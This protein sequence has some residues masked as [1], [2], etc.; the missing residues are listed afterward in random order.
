MKTNLLHLFKKHSYLVFGLIILVFTIAITYLLSYR[1]KPTFNSTSIFQDPEQIDTTIKPV[2]LGKYSYQNKNSLHQTSFRK[3][4]TNSSAIHF[5]NQYSDLSFFTNST[6]SFAEANPD[7]KPTVDGSTITYPAIFPHTDLRYTVEPNR[8]LEEFVINN[9]ETALTMTEITQTLDRRQIDSYKEVDGTIELY[10]NEQ[11]VATIPRPVMYEHSDQSIRSYDLNYTIKK[12]NNNTLSITKVVNDRGRDWLS[13]PARV[14][15]IVID[16]VIDNADTAASWVSSDTANT[17]VSQETTIKQE[18]TGSVKVATTAEADT[19]V[20]LM[21]YAPVTATGGTIT[22]SGGYTIHKFTSSGTFTP[23]GITDVE[24]LVVGG[25]GGGGETIGGGG[26]GGGILHSPTQVTATGHTVTVGAG[27]A[28]GWNGVGGTY[29]AGTKGS[30]SSFAGLVAKGGGAGGGYNVG[31]SVIGGSAGGNGAGGGSA[32]DSYT[33]GQGNSGGFN[34]GNTNT[35]GGGGGK[36]AAGSNATSTV[37]GSG[38]SGYTSTITGSSVTYAGGG[39]GGVRNGSGTAGSGGSGGGGAGGSSTA[40]TAGTANTG[41]GGGGGGYVSDLAGGAG[42]KGIVIIRYLTNGRTATPSY[43]NVNTNNTVSATGGTITNVG[44]FRIHKFTSGGTFTPNGAMNVEALVV[45]GGGGGGETIGGGGGGGGV[46][47]DTSFAVTATGYTITVGAGGAGGSGAGY[48]AGV[49]G[50]NSVFSTNTAIGG[51]AGAGYNVN[52]SGTGGS[53]GGGGGNGS[54]NAGYTPAQG[55]DGGN[56]GGA[57]ASGGGGGASA[58]GASYSGNNSGNGGDGLAFSITGEKLYYAGGGGGGVRNSTG[59][60]AGSAGTGGGGNGGKTTAGGGG[61]ANTGGGGGGGGYVSDLAGGAGGSGIVIIR[62]PFENEMPIGGIVTDVGDYRLH[63]YMST[64]TDIFVP[65]FST[66]VEVLMVGGGGGG[67]ETIGG[68]GGGG[69][70]IHNTS[71]AVTAGQHYQVTVGDGG[72]R[73]WDGTSGTY[74]AGSKGESSIFS[75]LTSIGG[76]GGAGYN[77]AAS[78]TGGSAG[79]NGAGGGA[80]AGYTAGQGNDGGTHYGNTN[81]SGGGGGKNAAGSNATSTVSGSGGSGYTSTI[82]GSSVTYAGGGGGGVRNGSGTAG[83]GGSGG[84]GTGGSSTAG[85]S[86]LTNTGGGGGGGGYV[87]DLAGGYGGSGIVIVKYLRPIQSY[88]ESSTKTQGSYALRGV[89]TTASLNKTLTR[90]VSPTLDLSDLGKINFS[91]RSTRTGSNIKIGI[92]D[93]GGTTTEITPNI[94]S[95]DSYQSIEWDISGVSNANKDAIDQIIITIVEATAANTFYIDNMVANDLSLN[96]TVTLTKS[97]TNLSGQD[98]ITYWVRSNTTGSFARFEF[99]ESASSEQTNAFTINSANT[100]EQ[101][102]WDITGIGGTSR[103]AVTKFAFKLT[104]DTN[105]AILYFDD[106]QTTLNNVAPNTPSLDL[107]TDTTTNQIFLPVLKTTTTDADSDYLRYKIELCEDVGMSVSCQT[108]DQTSS[109]TGWS[110]QNAETS[111]AYTSGTQGV[112]T[113]QS[114]LAVNDTFYWRSYAIDPGGTNTWSST[115]GTPY[116]FTTT[117]APTAPTT[118]Y[119]EGATNPTGVTDLTP[120]FSAVHNDGDGDSANY[121][122]IVVDTQVGFDGVEMWDS[123]K[124]SMTTTAN[125]V[126][127]PNISYA[128]TSLSLDNST[129]YWHIKF[130]D[131]L[132]AEGTYSATANFGMNIKPNTPSLDAPTDTNTNQSLLPDLQTTTTDADTDY[133]RYK[134][135]VCED[136]GM[137]SNCNTHDQTSSQTGWSGQDTQ[138]TT[139]YASGTQGTYTLQSVLD[140]STTYY[141]RSYAIDPAGAN[142]WSSTQGTPYSFTTTNNPAQQT[143]CRVQESNNDSSLTVIWTDTATNED[144]Y[145]V[146]RSKDAAAWSTLS[147]T[148]A[149]NSSSYVDNTIT[150]GST[151]RYR[152]APYLTAGSTYGQ[153]CYTNTLS[154]SSGNFTFEDLNFE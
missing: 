24:A 99:G 127:S 146:D 76:G 95:A 31:S 110:G 61:T 59:G 49:K 15:P 56:G 62:Y 117:T 3:D 152:V 86:G 23:N 5:A 71:F 9:Q 60:T 1:S 93:S 50:G 81:T 90:T 58:N 148:I 153:W 53:S 124:Q 129:Y 140:T 116:S 149:A 80:R 34:Y 135:Q 22:Y 147:S 77:G 96:D 52:A 111:T 123:G 28:G 33:P 154:V 10:R 112:Y 70:V 2:S 121:Y 108:F 19:T 101:K 41:G 130:W 47:H 73:G 79:G 72:D 27:G 37:S 113:L 137:S 32:R 42:G 88:S 66:N 151:Y 57:N 114:A 138:S 16:L 103:D 85:T 17:V 51:G 118:P 87:S 35:S 142:T 26:G 141:W 136:V 109:Q 144:F 119:A 20:D 84:G 105:G 65:S 83:S 67:G 126:R 30:D 104:S 106:I 45:G 133:L 132:G 6:Q 139:A 55:N 64:G 100:W 128:G 43:L 18:G 89:A 125:G 98:N 29:P 150:T 25:G 4:P 107:P 78:G 134:I 120:E 68:G 63:T 143:D 69:G 91:L 122:Q 82:T 48:P 92:H 102:T 94:T 115:Q 14:Y 75:T 97:A 54:L 21:E 7:A 39:G 131:T 11:L 46:I 40:G 8:L 12:I 13:D 38:G 36:N 74:P 145:Q 44:G